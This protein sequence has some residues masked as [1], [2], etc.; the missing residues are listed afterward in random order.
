MN[1]YTQYKSQRKERK[2][3]RHSRRIFWVG[4]VLFLYPEEKDHD[5]TKPSTK[6]IQKKS[7]KKKNLLNTFQSRVLKEENV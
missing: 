5:K 2:K 7:K 1:Q 4:V 6:S 3:E